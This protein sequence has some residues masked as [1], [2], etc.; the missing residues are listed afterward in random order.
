MK[1]LKTLGLIGL[2]TGAL[3][4]LG[5]SASATTLTSPVGTSYTG[6]FVAESTTK[7]QIHRNQLFEGA[8]NINCAKSRLEGQV[9]SH[10]VGVT[11]TVRLTNVLFMECVTV[12]YVTET[13]LLKPGNLEIH[14]A[15]G[16]TEGTTGNGTV[17]YAKNPFELTIKW[18]TMAGNGEHCI[19][20]LSNGD[21]GSIRGSKS[22][23]GTAAFE[24]RAFLTT[25]LGCGLTAELTGTYTISTPDNLNVD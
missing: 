7:V 18:Q 16:D 10:G 9:E 19:F 14:T 8:F 3:L 11:A 2:A 13:V 17:T 5:G 4:A 20:K 25:S 1:H 6:K 24:L 22:L 15:S 23:G 12:A 21:I